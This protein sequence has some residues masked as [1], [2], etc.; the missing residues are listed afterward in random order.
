MLGRFP[1]T[2]RDKSCLSRIINT[3]LVF[4]FFLRQLPIGIVLLRYCSYCLLVEITCTCLSFFCR[5]CLSV[6]Y[7]F[8]FISNKT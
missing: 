2:Q 7:T 6:S 3:S 1:N 8:V 4:V 5:Y